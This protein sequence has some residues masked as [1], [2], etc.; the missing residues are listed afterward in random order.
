M[1][2]LAV[3][4][5]TLCPWLK[6]LE[7]NGKNYRCNSLANVRCSSSSLPIPHTKKAKEVGPSG[8]DR[9]LLMFKPK[10]N[11]SWLAVC[12]LTRYKVLIKASKKTRVREKKSHFAM[13]LLMGMTS[14]CSSLILVVNL[15]CWLNYLSS[16]LLFFFVEAVF[17]CL[18]MFDIEHVST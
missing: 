4:M 8:R 15:K 13:V 2:L 10:G 9:K 6:A 17:R 3:A 1:C 14:V 7:E 11:E 12:V 18:T 16:G 5:I